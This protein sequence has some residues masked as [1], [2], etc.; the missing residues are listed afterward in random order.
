[1]GNRLALSVV[2]RFLTHTRECAISY[3]LPYPK[4]PEVSEIQT[5]KTLFSNTPL[6][7]RVGACSRILWEQSMLADGNLFPAPGY[8]ILP[9]TVANVLESRRFATLT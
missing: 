3:T 2:R 8:A 7:P 9:L 6:F 4:R 5:L 1:M